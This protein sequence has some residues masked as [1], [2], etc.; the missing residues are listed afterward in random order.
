MRKKI[1]VQYFHEVAEDIKAI[2]EAMQE[3]DK[4]GLKDNTVVILIQ[5]ISGENKTTIRN[6]LEAMR[7][8]KGLLK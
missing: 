7:N 1:E 6:V 3:I 8:M 4:S 2:S 5:A